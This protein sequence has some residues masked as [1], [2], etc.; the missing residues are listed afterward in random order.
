MGAQRYLIAFALFTA[1]ASNIVT[2]LAAPAQKNYARSLENSDVWAKLT[3]R[4]KFD[5]YGW[6]LSPNSSND[7]NGTGPMFNPIPSTL[8]Q[9][10]VYNASTEFDF[11]SL[12]SVVSSGVF[13][14]SSLYEMPIYPYVQ[15]LTFISSWL[16]Y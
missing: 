13:S 2:V 5:A 1:L 12:V 10:P 3:K 9:N 16:C 8:E 11:G 14:S 7:R 6:T 4:D 15:R